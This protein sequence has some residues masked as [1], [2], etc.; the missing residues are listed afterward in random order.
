M[1]V[2]TEEWCGYKIR[3]VE[4]N[5]EWMAV[6]KDI[7]DALDLKSYK[8]AQRLDARLME[9]VPIEVET[10]I[11]EKY[12]K[13]DDIPS[14]DGISRNTFT[15]TVNMLVISEIGIYEALFASRKLEARKFRLWTAEVL[16]KL[17]GFVGLQGFEV[18]RMTDK[19]IQDQIDDILDDLFWDEE[20]GELMISVVVEGG[21]ADQIP[22]EE[23]VKNK[24]E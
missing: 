3:F 14:R 11:P 6:L 18:M 5:G 2:R 12:A 24:G 19:D 21:D 4:Y 20:R 7:C 10:D 23:Y 16:K 9:K 8:V 17:R 15:K 13:K 1:N 22:F